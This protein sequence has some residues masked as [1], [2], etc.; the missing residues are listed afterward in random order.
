MSL[1][2]WFLLFCVLARALLA[3]QVQLIA[4][5]ET[6]SYLKGYSEPS[7]NGALRWFAPGYN[8]SGWATGRSGFSTPDR[9]GEITL[10]TDYNA[11]YSTVYFRKKF[12]ATN[13]S[14]IAELVLRADYDDGFVAYLNGHE[15]ARRGVPGVVNAPVPFNAVATYHLR[16]PGETVVLTNAAQ[17]MVDGMNVL[18][19]QVAGMGGSDLNMSFVPELLANVIRGPYVQNTTSASSQIIW[20]TL[21]AV[22]SA[23]EYGTNITQFVRQ[24]VSASAT[25]HVAAIRGL[26]PDT[27]YFYRVVNRFDS[28][29]T[30]TDW[31]SFRTFKLSGPV[32]FNVVGDSGWASVAQLQ[33]AEQMERAPADFLMHVGDIVYFAI[34]HYN[35]DLRNFSIYR[36]E[37]RNRPWFLALGNHEMYGDPKAALELFHLPTN[38]VTGTEHYY[39][40]D[41]GDVHFAVAWSDLAAGSKYDPTSP[42]FQW[43]DADLGASTKPWKFL[44]FHHTWR[45][46]GPHQVDDYDRNLQKDY[47]QMEQGVVFLAR[48]H[49]VP[50]IFNGHDH[51]YERLVPSGGPMSFI[52]GGGGAN[53]YPTSTPHVDSAQLYLAHHFLRVHVDGPKAAIEAVGVDG[54]VFDT[55]HIRRG[56]PER[57]VYHARWNTPWIETDSVA[58]SDGNVFGQTFDFIGEPVNGP[59]GL[60]SS[61]GRMF[62]NNDQHH[63]Y[64]GFDEVMLRPGEELFLFVEVPTLSGVANL[65]RIGNGVMDPNGE[66]ADGLDFLANLA[67]ENFAPSIGVILGDEFGDT[68]A[69]SFLRAGQ[70]IN[71]GQGAFYLAPGTAGVPSQRLAQFNRSPHFTAVAHEQNADLIELSVPFDALGGIKPGDIIRVGAVVGLRT[72]DTNSAMQSRIIDIGGIGYSVLHNNDAVVLEGVEVQLASAPYPDQDGDGLA[73]YDELSRGT[74]PAESDSDRDGM[75]DGWEALYGFNPLLRDESN[76]S[77]GD[78]LENGMEFRAGTDPR[79]AQSRLAAQISRS[80]DGQM[81]FAW[82][83]VAGKRY[84]V[85]NRDTLSEP[86]RDVSDLNLPF[87]AQSSVSTYWINFSPDQDSRT[88]YYRVQLVE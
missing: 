32:T 55:V 12:T 27:T 54:R 51:H 9:Y 69:P 3:D 72:I 10:F 17:Y 62:V 2:R 67:F 38:S 24:E 80:S 37:M 1:A 52:S 30:F 45:T 8:D 68:N 19:V 75:S 56:F 83:S 21:S 85:Q 23:I 63:L 33:I 76:D 79:N 20:A 84:R 70:S 60:F 25:N 13:I 61:V 6:W 48:K 71:T 65:Q 5:G 34:T 29:E 57:E 64:V 39:S 88:R 18:A 14:N 35:A 49:G 73:D 78:G 36:E 22:A 43:L 87:V 74:D 4:S 42:Q 50:V 66:G 15:V 11:G 58:D 59:M 47:D 41:H 86:F 81:R 46:S 7:T 77:D 16:G 82:S 40:F 31:Y 44:F 53:L 26:E 28:V